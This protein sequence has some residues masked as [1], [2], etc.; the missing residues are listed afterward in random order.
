M[1]MSDPVQLLSPPL[2]APSPQNLIT[3]SPRPLIPPISSLCPSLWPLGVYGADW[4]VSPS[5][6]HSGH[7]HFSAD[8]RCQSMCHRP[9]MYSL[10]TC[11][12]QVFSLTKR[13]ST[14]EF[15]LSGWHFLHSV[16]SA[17]GQNMSF[18]TALYSDTY[19]RSLIWR[20]SQQ[21]SI[22]CL[23]LPKLIQIPFVK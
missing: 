22:I 18:V 20:P 16:K 11:S 13:D 23:C 15:F 10:P 21:D 2:L 4:V 7:T 14:D 12:L 3:S 5:D 17:G 1:R 8:H 9:H 19:K 6:R